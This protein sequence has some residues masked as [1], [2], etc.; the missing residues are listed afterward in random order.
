MKT[1]KIT[2][3]NKISVVNVNFSDFKA[4]Q[5]AIGGYFEIVNTQKLRDY[6]KA[7]VVMIVDE[8]GVI[9]DLPVNTIGC[10]FYNTSKHGCPIAGDMILGLL[11]GPDITGLGDRDAEQWMEK[12]LKD[13]PVL[14]KENS[15]E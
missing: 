2:T 11:V 1:L 14:Q 6:F 10:Y 12:M 9:K 13:F 15:H 7:S 8:E 3:D 5:Q 4:I